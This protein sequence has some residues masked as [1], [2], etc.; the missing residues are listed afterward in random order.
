ML[1]DMLNQIVQSNK[2]SGETD[3]AKRNCHTSP[4]GFQDT[5]QPHQKCHRANV[6]VMDLFPIEMRIA[7]HFF[8]LMSQPEI[9]RSMP[10]NAIT[11]ARPEIALTIRSIQ[12]KSVES[13]TAFLPLLAQRGAQVEGAGHPSWP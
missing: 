5:D 6:S 10:M 8:I 13:I 4:S 2:P 12:A 1:D 7:S 11:S 9:I 3:R